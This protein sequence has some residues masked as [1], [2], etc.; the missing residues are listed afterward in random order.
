MHVLEFSGFP[1]ALR[2]LEAW[3]DLEGALDEADEER[4]EGW[5]VLSVYDQPTALEN[6]HNEV[7]VL[8]KAPC[9]DD[10]A[11]AARA[12]PKLRRW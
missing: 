7:V 9:P 4:A 5:G 11:A 8:E 6:R 1:S 3:E 12:A 2:A 10:A